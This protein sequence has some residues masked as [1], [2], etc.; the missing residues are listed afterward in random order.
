VSSFVFLTF[1]LWYNS[2]WTWI[3]IEW[4]RKA[5]SCNRKNAT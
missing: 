5:K 2:R 1:S 4:R 3:K